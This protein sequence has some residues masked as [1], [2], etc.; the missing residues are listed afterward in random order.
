[1]DINLSLDFP[2]KWKEIKITA[3]APP[4]TFQ[5][6]SDTEDHR[7]WVDFHPDTGSL[8]LSWMKIRY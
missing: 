3:L 7:M 1:M 4:P 6:A 2:F 8:E 5:D